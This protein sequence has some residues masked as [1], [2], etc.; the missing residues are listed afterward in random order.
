VLFRFVKAPDQQLAWCG[1]C[2]VP[3]GLQKW[4]RSRPVRFLKVTKSGQVQNFALKFPIK[5][6]FRKACRGRGAKEETNHHETSRAS[7]SGAKPA[8]QKRQRRAARAPK[9]RHT[10]ASGIAR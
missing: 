4:D 10:P 6:I 7:F 8:S 1:T 2:Q 5:C 9:Q 3:C